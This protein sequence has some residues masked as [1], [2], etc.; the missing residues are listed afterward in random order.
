MQETNETILISSLKSI[1]SSELK[2]YEKMI[3]I[4]LKMYHHEYGDVFPDY[5][6][7]AVSGGMSKRKAQYV[8]KD[9]S[10]KQ[11]ISKV[12]RFKD[13]PDGTRMQTSNRY[14]N[15]RDAEP[16]E[17]LNESQEVRD[18]KYALASNELYAQDAP[19]KARLFNQESFDLYPFTDYKNKEEEDYITRTHEIALTKYARY[20]QVYKEM[21]SDQGTGVLSYL[22]I[23][24]LDNCIFYNFPLALVRTIY[25]R[26]KGDMNKYHFDSIHRTFLK[27]VER[28]SRKSIHNPIAW[29]VSTYRNEDIKVRS[30]YNLYMG[31]QTVS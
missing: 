25:S 11:I 12:H 18:A 2:T 8:V 26:V 13:K 17:I 4:V 1:L 30:E 6:T 22:Q 16:V 31:T 20:A 29:F 24:F 21:I 14:E 19:Y 3:M 9:L 15:I 5:E 7:I 23:E 10:N 28:L 27:Y